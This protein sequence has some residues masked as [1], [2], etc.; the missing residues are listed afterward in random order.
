M[1]K[2]VSP[3]SSGERKDAS[4][5]DSGEKTRGENTQNPVDQGIAGEAE[6]LSKAVSGDAEAFGKLYD[7][8][9]RRLYA[10]V[11]RL[12]RDE[13]KALDIVQDAFVR[14]YEGLSGLHGEA[15]FFPWIRRIAVNLAVDVLRRR[16]RIREVPLLGE[17]G[18]DADAPAFDRT[19]TEAFSRGPE[20][21][22][23]QLAATAEFGAALQE[24][25]E[26]LSE[27]HRVVF[28]LHAAEG[29]RY[30]E[31]AETLSINVGTVMS[32]LFY[33]RRRLQ[34]LLASHLETRRVTETKEESDERP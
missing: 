34:D 14:A 30:R 10:T 9:Y 23:A 24:A 1:N 33:A 27:D 19:A 11:W 29:L 32:R 15:H 12:L 5:S 25:L 6:L 18:D 4:A 22:P 20:E 31:I 3:P 16:K 7:L 21:D 26:Q 2:Y 8:H 17:A 28:L 13:D